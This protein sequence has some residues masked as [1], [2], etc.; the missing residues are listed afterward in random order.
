V[1]RNLGWWPVVLEEGEH[2]VKEPQIEEDCIVVG[3]ATIDDG[4]A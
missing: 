4:R 1:R 3:M 2:S